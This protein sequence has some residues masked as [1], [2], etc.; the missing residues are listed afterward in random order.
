MTIQ[1]AAS[2]SPHRKIWFNEGIQLNEVLYLPAQSHS[3]CDHIAIAV[4]NMEEII[5]SSVQMGCKTLPDKS[6][7]IVLPN[8]TVIELMINN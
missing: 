1:K 2:V 7:W 8:N 6:G 4:D 5:S 3:F